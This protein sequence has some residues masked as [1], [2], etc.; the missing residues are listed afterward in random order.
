M[1]GKDAR[2]CKV[3]KALKSALVN[4]GLTDSYATNIVDAVKFAIDTGCD[5]DIHAKEKYKKA[6]D[7]QKLKDLQDAEKKRL[8]EQLGDYDYYEDYDDDFNF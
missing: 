1:L 7:A 4:A 5:Y 8:K 6:Q 2:T 3:K